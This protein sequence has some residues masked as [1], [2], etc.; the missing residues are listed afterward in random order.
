MRLGSEPEVPHKDDEVDLDDVPAVAAPY[1]DALRSVGS[2][3]GALPGGPAF[4]TLV[5]GVLESLDDA[6][7]EAAV[8]AAVTAASVRAA[9]DNSSTA[10]RCRRRGLHRPRHRCLRRSCRRCRCKPRRRKG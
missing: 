9:P 6:A 3:W 2:G 10:V 4:G 1:D 7:D 8:R 5:H